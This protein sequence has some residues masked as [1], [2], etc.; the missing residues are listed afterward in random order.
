MEQ[1][2]LKRPYHNMVHAADV[3]QSMHA[4]LKLGGLSSGYADPLTTL[5]C[6]LAA[7]IHDLG[8]LGL[9]NDFLVNTA[10]LLAIRYNDR[11][12]QV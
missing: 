12:P 3:L 11:A 6:Y 4:I 5:A 7:V 2:Y 10:N 1:G 8:H 9:T